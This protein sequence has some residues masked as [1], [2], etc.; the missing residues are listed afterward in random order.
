MIGALLLML[1][2][3][4][5]ARTGRGDVATKAWALDYDINLIAAQRLVDHQDIYS[6]ARLGGDGA[7]ARRAPT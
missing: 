1:G 7:R 5:F 4:D 2:V 3:L 6:A